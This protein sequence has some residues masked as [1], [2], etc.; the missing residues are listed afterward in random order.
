MTM[1]FTIL[2]AIKLTYRAVRAAVGILLVLHG[3]YKWVQ[4]KRAAVA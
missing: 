1:F 4:N 3:T 2:R